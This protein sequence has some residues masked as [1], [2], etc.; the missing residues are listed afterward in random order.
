M[1]R[2]TIA[3][4]LLMALLMVASCSNDDDSMPYAPELQVESSEVTFTAVG[5]TG[6]I[7]FSPETA[8]V[9]ATS[10]DLWCKVTVADQHTVT[11]STPAYEDLATRNAIVTI[12]DA[13]GHT[14]HVAVTQT[15]LVLMLDANRLRMTD[16]AATGTVTCSH[17][18]QVT[19]SASEPWISGA[20]EDNNIRV[21]C[22]ANTT[23]DMRVGY[24][25]AYSAGEKDSILV[26]Q[27]ER[28]DILGDY[29][30]SGTRTE[31]NQ[32]VYLTV[33][34][35]EYDE[36]RVT[37]SIPSY[38]WRILTTCDDD[39]LSLRLTAGTRMGYIR[40]DDNKI[41]YMFLNLWDTEA[42]YYTWLTKYS[43]DFK[44][45]PREG[46]GTVAYLSDN[47][48]WSPCLTDALRFDKYTSAS[49]TT[50]SAGLWM[51]LK[52]PFLRK[53]RDDDNIQTLPASI[54]RR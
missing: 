37:I 29:Y 13:K 17:S 1:K 22:Q 36:D 51:A 12:A 18:S 5:G 35:T 47:G 23:G 8:I 7:T 40:G 39:N 9:S 24:L 6:T 31:D 27:G 53:V 32:Q 15:G 45:Q 2:M 11:V 14:A 54:A 26:I 21:T 33:K 30:L 49:A 42:G 19:F 38:G 10:S 4:M 43:V 46:G 16:E 44:F 52:D 50:G 34:L 28:K 25:Y 48:S 41:Y 20:I 3:S